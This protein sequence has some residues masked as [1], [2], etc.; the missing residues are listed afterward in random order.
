MNNTFWSVLVSEI[1]KFLQGAFLEIKGF[2]LWAL[3]HWK[4]IVRWILAGAIGT[5]AVWVTARYVIYFFGY[6]VSL[7]YLWGT[8]GLDH[9]FS[10]PLSILFG[11]LF[12][13]FGLRF[14]W[15]MLLGRNKPRSVLILV[16]VSAVMIVLP[17]TI[18]RDH[19]FNR[20]TGQPTKCFAR[21]TEGFK[22][23]SRC[24]F[25]PVDGVQYRPVT[26]EDMDDI[27][28]WEKYG[29]LA[30]APPVEPGKYFDP[31]T[32]KPI[33]WYTEVDGK[34]KLHSLRVHDQKIGVRSLPITPAI[35]ERYETE[36]RLAEKSLEDAERIRAVKEHAQAEAE[37]LARMPKAPDRQLVLQAIQ[38]S[39]ADQ[40][41]IPAEEDKSLIWQMYHGDRSA[42]LVAGD[43]L[44]DKS[45]A[46]FRIDRIV[47]LGP[48]KLV[49]IACTNPSKLNTP[50][51]KIA[52]QILDRNAHGIPFRLVLTE[53]HDV[54][55]YEHSGI[56]EVFHMRMN[57]YETTRV[58][59]VFE[60]MSEDQFSFLYLNA[61]GKANRFS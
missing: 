40:K 10:G 43:S 26:R 21:T 31:L 22:F 32:G 19:S 6:E 12:L 29:S 9:V 33:V 8:L 2:V 27:R 25:D 3:A 30:S 18:G 14:F 53:H 17:L 57:P 60:D 56:G 61:L 34:I 55:V 41:G 38:R 52:L 4:F 39:L 13:L 24:D 54:Y 16:T 15:N 58:L 1:G 42:R 35:I 28:A 49:G 11:S 59:F 23:S 37:R 47:T 50:D 48:Y 45:W 5:L 44:S 51:F 46:E 7:G 36:R 20:M